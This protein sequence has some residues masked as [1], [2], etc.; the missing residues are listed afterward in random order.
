MGTGKLRRRATGFTLLESIVV[1]A[2]LGIVMVLGLPALLSMH[3]R[4]QVEQS[5]RRVAA[6]IARA[7][8]EAIRNTRAVCVRALDAAAQAG[9][10][11]SAFSDADGDCVL[12]PGDLEIRG[13]RMDL[14]PNVVWRGPG[15]A[16]DADG[17]AAAL[18]TLPDGRSSNRGFTFSATGTSSGIGAL[19]IARDGALDFLEVRIP[20]ASVGRVVVKKFSA[21]A[22]AG[23]YERQERRWEWQ[24]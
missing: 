23:W 9:P 15:G 2:I 10:G 19:R 1:V 21:V 22:P 16:P 24:Q 11:I 18:L 7:R 5:A 13:L 20:N 3:R 6:G 4:S 14:D 8:F 12:D 17:F